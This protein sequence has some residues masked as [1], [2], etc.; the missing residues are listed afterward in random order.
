VAVVLLTVAYAVWLMPSSGT[1]VPGWL[2]GAS[3]ALGLLTFGSVGIFA[4]TARRAAGLAMVLCAGAAMTV[5]PVVASVSV[6]SNDLGSFDTPFQPEALTAFNKAF[7]GAPLRPIASLPTI[8]H[9][10]DGARDLLAAQTSVVAAPFI[11][12][13]GQEVVPIGGYDGATP[14][15]TIGTL[16]T[17]IARG[18]FHLVLSAPHSRDP[19]ILW[20]QAH[21]TAVHPSGAT[22]AIA[23]EVSYCLAGAAAHGR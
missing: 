4:T 12:A 22:P 14:S 20:I 5:A 10:R 23:L 15:P 13:T 1:G 19:R 16:R 18:Q 2:A 17:A 21:C 6:V 8:E 9:V 11:F 3:V 7:F